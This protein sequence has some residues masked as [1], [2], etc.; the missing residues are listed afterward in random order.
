MGVSREVIRADLLALI[1]CAGTHLIV[2][3]ACS[4]SQ[5]RFSVRNYTRPKGNVI[6]SIATIQNE[7]PMLKIVLCASINSEQDLSSVLLLPPIEALSSTW[8]SL[9][10]AEESILSTP[11]PKAPAAAF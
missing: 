3:A 2:D 5:V 4:M 7:P 1:I 6:D 11:R 10:K 9:T 8:N